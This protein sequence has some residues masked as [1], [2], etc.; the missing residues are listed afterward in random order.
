VPGIRPQFN[1][2]ASA[3]GIRRGK[4]IVNRQISEDLRDALRNKLP[5]FNPLMRL[6]ELAE[7]D[8]TEPE[9]KVQCLTAVLPFLVPKAVP[10]P[11]DAKASIEYETELAK[12][13]AGAVGGELAGL[14][15]RLTRGRERLSPEIRARIAAIEAGKPEPVFSRP[16]VTI[17]AQA[18]PA[19]PPR[20][21]PPEPVAP[22][23][24]PEPPRVPRRDPAAEYASDLDRRGNLLG[25]PPSPPVPPEILEEE[26]QRQLDAEQAEAARQGRARAALGRMGRMVMEPE[27]APDDDD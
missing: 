27:G 7:A 24:A 17:D 16:A 22:V 8:D 11:V 10:H 20:D 3:K 19:P 25:L 21:V 23:P 1:G 15:D 13:R 14:A 5:D 18:V 6:I 2:N 9:L 12:V 26:R 4:L